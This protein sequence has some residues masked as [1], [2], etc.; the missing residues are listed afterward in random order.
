MNRIR[1]SQPKRISIDAIIFKR[2]QLSSVNFQ[3]ACQEQQVFICQEYGSSLLYNSIDG[4]LE[5][6]L[7]FLSNAKA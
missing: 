5:L 4:S 3:Y 1:V 6:M 7:I 2:F